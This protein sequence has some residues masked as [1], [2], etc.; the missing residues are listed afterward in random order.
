MTDQPTLTIRS[1]AALY[2]LPLLLFALAA[3]VIYPYY[4]YRIVSD[5][6]S[7]LTIARRYLA[8]DYHTAINGYWSPLNIWLLVALVKGTGWS[9][10]LASYILNC[11]SFAGLLAM[12]IRLAMRFTQHVFELAGL[13]FCLAFFWAANIPV[14]HFADALNSFL[15]LACLLIL[16]NK[17]FLQKPALWILF[18]FTGAIAYFSKAYSFYILPLTTAVLVFMFLKNESSFTVK[19][20]LTILCV[21]TGSMILF[22]F[23]WIMILHNKYGFWGV[24][25]AGGINTN[26]AIYGTMYFSERYSIVVPPAY[27]DGLSCWEDPWINKGKMISAFGSPSLFLKQVYRAGVNVLQWFKVTGEFSPFYFPVWLLSIIYLVRKKI[28]N[29]NR[30]KAALMLAF[31]VFPVGYLMLSFGTRYLWFT[32]PLVMITGLFFFRNYFLPLLQPKMYRLLLVIYFISWWPGAI[33]EMKVTLNEGK[34]DYQIA[35]LMEQNGIKGSFIGNDYTNYQNHFRVSWFTGNPFYMYF[36]NRYSTAQLLAEAKRLKVKYY[37]YYY[38]GANNDYKL[39]DDSGK[40][41]T[42][43]AAGKLPGIKVFQLY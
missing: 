4:Q 2:I 34:E 36:G 25:S 21:C 20:W 18:G 19:K 14:T 43:V 5:D 7:Y 6:I 11:V 31:V 39:L 29:Y 1:R 17:S 26:W 28:T 22:S 10:L 8:G 24:S 9:L 37:F 3:M 12:C 33:Q 41:F 42:E 38:N 27:P 23:P 16:L 32:V 40:P 35:Q 30:N 15:L 13:G